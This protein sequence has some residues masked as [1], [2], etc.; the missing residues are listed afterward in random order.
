[1]KHLVNRL[2]VAMFNAILRR[3]AEDMPTDPAFDPISDP[4]ILPIPIGQSSFRA[5][6][7]LKNAVSRCAFHQI[8]FVASCWAHIL[9]V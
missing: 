2:D 6:A 5:G 7:Q 8:F 4:N 9:F 3:S 1:M